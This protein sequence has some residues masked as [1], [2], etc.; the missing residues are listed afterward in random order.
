MKKIKGKLKR[1]ISHEQQTIESAFDIMLENEIS[2]RSEK[3]IS[4][5]LSSSKPPLAHTST[6]R[7]TKTKSLIQ[8]KRSNNFLARQND[9]AIGF[10]VRKIVTSKKPSSK[11][12]F[13]NNTITV[14]RSEYIAKKSSQIKLVRGVSKTKKILKLLGPK[15]LKIIQKNPK[16]S[17]NLRMIKFRYSYKL[18]GKKKTQYYSAKS[19]KLK[20][21]KQLADYMRRTIKAFQ[22]D[23]QTYLSRGFSNI[24]VEG[25]Q[26]QSYK[27]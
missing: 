14:I 7:S 1:R 22:D 5:N 11:R 16:S 23:L 21:R 8:P 2:K 10:S 18:N 24:T 26:I 17:K 3:T 19:V 27:E 25:I 4:K 12:H 20:N 9:R 15:A 6:N 13:K